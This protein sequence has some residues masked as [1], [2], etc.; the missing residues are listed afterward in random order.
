MSSAKNPLLEAFAKL[1]SALRLPLS[2]GTT[3]DAT[4]TTADSD[5][6][7]KLRLFLHSLAVALRPDNMMAGAQVSQV[8]GLVN[9]TA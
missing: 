9:V 7:G 4:T 2:A 6:S 8:G 3:A 5:M 1:F